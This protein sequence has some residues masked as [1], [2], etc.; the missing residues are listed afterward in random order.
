VVI[1]QRDLN[2]TG[3]IIEFN[4]V[5]ADEG[6]DLEKAAAIVLILLRENVNLGR[7]D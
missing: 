1:I 5:D 3:I 2:Q 6:E 7:N 4:K